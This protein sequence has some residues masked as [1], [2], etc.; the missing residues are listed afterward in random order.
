MAELTRVSISLE[1]AL[2]SAFDVNIAS[3]GYATRSEAIRDL[4]RAH[5]VRQESQDDKSGAA[6]QVAVVTLVYDHHARELA[7]RLIDK[8]HHHHDLVVSS[9]HVHLG[10]RHC[11][12]VSVLRGAAAEV[13]HLGEE[14]LSIRGVLHGDITYTSGESAFSRWH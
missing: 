9:L 14:L 7:A 13:R 1:N 2:L 10:E 11:L 4:I 5:L 8:Q 6:E 12:E 3:Q